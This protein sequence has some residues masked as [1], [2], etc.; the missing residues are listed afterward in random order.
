MSTQY[1]IPPDA[2]Q[3][4]L[5]NEGMEGFC[6][7]AARKNLPYPHISAPQARTKCSWNGNHSL[8]ILSVSE[9]SR[10]P[11]VRFFA[12]AQNDKGKR[13]MTV[14]ADPLFARCAESAIRW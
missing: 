5:F 4:R 12:D 10:C 2:S 8:V 3:A 14:V 1:L 7:P 13:R 9:E 11:S 6:A